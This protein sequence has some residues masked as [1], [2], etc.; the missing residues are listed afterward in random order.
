M[1]LTYRAD[2]DLVVTPIY[3]QNKHLRGHGSR[4][5]VDG[6]VP[7]TAFFRCLAHGLHVRL[8][9]E[10]P[11]KQQHYSLVVAPAFGVVLSTNVQDFRRPIRKSCELVEV[12]SG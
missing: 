5:I 4:I 2:P 11:R 9:P 7:R 12:G 1:T 3:P 10:D 6:L 8:D